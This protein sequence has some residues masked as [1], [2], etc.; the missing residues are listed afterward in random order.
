VDGRLHAYK[1]R[2]P[3][4]TERYATDLSVGR[5]GVAAGHELPGPTCE[6][7]AANPLLG[8]SS[9]AGDG[10]QVALHVS[11]RAASTVAR[12]GSLASRSRRK[13][14]IA[15]IGHDQGNLQLLLVDMSL[16][17]SYRVSDR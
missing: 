10:R 3:S 6:P 8:A 13:R 15:H 16:A 7:P 4:S 11:R 14:Q 1:I 12:R 9:P 5:Q 2:N 17:E